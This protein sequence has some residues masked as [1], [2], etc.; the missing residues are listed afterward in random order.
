MINFLSIAC[1]WLFALFAIAMLLFARHQI[2]ERD[3]RIKRLQTDNTLLCNQVSW[4]ARELA[5]YRAIVE[6]RVFGRPPAWRDHRGFAV[7]AET[8]RN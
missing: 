3:A 2:T 6:Q 4:D 8:E 5:T 7:S 1:I